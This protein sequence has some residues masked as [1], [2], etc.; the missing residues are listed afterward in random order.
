MPVVDDRAVRYFE[1]IRSDESNRLTLTSGLAKAAGEM[2]AA[3]VAAA[4]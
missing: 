4:R 1:E 3:L 2:S